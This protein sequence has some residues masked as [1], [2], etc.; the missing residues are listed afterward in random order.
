PR[1]T[2][3]T[4]RTV[5]RKALLL[6]PVVALALAAC[7]AAPPPPEPPAEPAAPPE[8]LVV[9]GHASVLEFGPVLLASTEVPPG[10]VVTGSGGVP[11][12]W[13]AQDAQLSSGVSGRAASGAAPVTSGIADLAGNA[14]TQTLRMSLEHDDARIVMT[15]TEGLYRIVARKSAGIDSIEDL[16]GKRV[17]M[18]AN[19]SAAVF[20][21]DVL[22]TAGLTENDV[23]ISSLTAPA[24]ADALINGEVDA[25]SI[26]EPESERA[27]KALGDDAV[28]FRP[29]GAYREIYSLNAKAG[30]LADPAK[31]ARIVEFLRAV[32]DGCRA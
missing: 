4:R 19:T 32:T 28:T 16:E 11:N 10:T 9:V 23:T 12:L 8:P 20:L 15:V 21:S 22:R 26:W 29:E 24:S 14:G 6:G 27:A 13:N 18:F 25:I 31:R 5:M 3:S 7:A 17:A 2:R 1:S 30:D